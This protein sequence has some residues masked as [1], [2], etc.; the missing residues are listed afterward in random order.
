MADGL[1]PL[2]WCG[3]S[4]EVYDKFP[5][6]VVDDLGFQL[7]RVQK[8][9][10]PNSY[11]S[12]APGVKQGAMEIKVKDRSGQYRV[13]YVTK[14]ADAVHILHCFKKT[15]KETSKADID[16]ANRELAKLV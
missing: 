8:G 13:I 1:K 5:E 7:Y 14:F 4:K 11:D 15:T 9:F 12:M 6:G 3:N 16:A 10:L 2:V